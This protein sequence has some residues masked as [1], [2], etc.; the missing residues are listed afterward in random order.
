MSTKEKPTIM[1]FRQFQD[2][3]V[4]A[5]M[6][7]EPGTMDPATCVSYM[8]VGQHGSCDPKHLVAITKPCNLC[9][10]AVL[11]RELEGIGYKVKAVSRLNRKYAHTRQ[12]SLERSAR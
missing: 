12:R 8:H 5:I 9:M 6:P 2:G 11:R 7:E 4:V 3:D 1:V 10:S